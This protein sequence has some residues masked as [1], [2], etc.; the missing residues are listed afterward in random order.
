MVNLIAFWMHFIYKHC[1]NCS[2]QWFIGIYLENLNIS[3]KKV[4]PLHTFLPRHSA[5]Q[6]S[7]VN[8]LKISINQSTNQ[9]INQLINESING[10]QSFDLL[11][12][13]WCSWWEDICIYYFLK[14][15][16]FISNLCFLLCLFLHFVT[17]FLFYLYLTPIKKG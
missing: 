6:E 1:I 8:I 7:C 13:L 14:S 15:S 11:I 9:S 2:L 4:L 12:D 17:T 5:D 16:L 10:T 3:C